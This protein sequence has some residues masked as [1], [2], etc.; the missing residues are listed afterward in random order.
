MFMR[1]NTLNFIIDLLTLLAILGMIGT[2]LLVKYVL[3]AG[4]GSRG[5][6]LW[7]L[8][9]HDWGDVHFW[10]AVALGVLLLLHVA[11]HWAWVCGS[12]RR[13][14]HPS[15][16]PG[17]PNATLDNLFGVGFIVLLVIIFGAFLFVADRAVVSSPARAAEHEAEHEGSRADRPGG[18]RRQGRNEQPPAT[19]GP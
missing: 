18:G 10:L 19:T 7:S 8:G 14:A 11:L 16:R 2:G 5:L 13:L 12:I 6:E 1:K 15:R 4:S 17:R 3:P 9:R